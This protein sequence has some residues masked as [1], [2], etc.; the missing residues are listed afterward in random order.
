ML[1]LNY[2]NYLKNKDFNIEKAYK[3]IFTSSFQITTKSK[4]KKQIIIR[5]QFKT[6]KRNIFDDKKNKS[7]QEIFT[8]FKE[9]RIDE[10]DVIFQNK[11]LENILTLNQD[12][13]INIL[14]KNK[15]KSSLSKLKHVFNYDKFQSEITK[16]FTDNFDFRTCFY[17][18]KDFITNF[19]ADKE[20]STFQLDHFYDKGTYPYLAL[21]FYNLIPS[22][23]T[24]N[25][26]K[27]KG[28]ANTFENNC[29][30]PNSQ[31]FD[32][33]KKVKFKLLLDDS[34][35]NLHIKSKNDIDI[36][37]KEQFTDIY[38]KYIEIFKL[39]E[40]YKAHKD[41]VFNMIQKAELYPQSRLK[42][43][44]NLTGIPFQQIK[45]DIFNLIDESEDLSKQPF[46][47]L[48]V[49]MSKEL[50]II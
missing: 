37:L 11:D 35:K 34:C 43:L 47:K 19:E 39:N 29:I 7:L 15:N 21:S 22:C 17:C 31:N 16:F 10:F 8:K 30:A 6:N 2:S 28:S 27:V 24:C 50:G 12:E 13:I 25:S 20:V 26:K 23:P 42:E 40:R 36:T 46:S 9:K 38:D 5:N 3:K 48:I 4:N 49:D 41:I 33:H 44:E 18:N 1:K 32:F 45:K 14:E